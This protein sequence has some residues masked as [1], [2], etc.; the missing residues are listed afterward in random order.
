MK[1]KLLELWDRA[2]SK[3]SSLRETLFGNHGQ[4]TTPSAKT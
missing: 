1:D 4:A 3:L 2:K